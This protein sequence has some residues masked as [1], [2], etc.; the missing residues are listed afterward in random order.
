MPKL[1]IETSD[2]TIHGRRGLSHFFR[3]ILTVWTNLGYLINI[4]FS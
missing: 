4:S 1:F 2:S 3:L